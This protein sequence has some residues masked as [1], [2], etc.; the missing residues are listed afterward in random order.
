[1]DEVTKFHR[2]SGLGGSLG[3][4][5]PIGERGIGY[6]CNSLAFARWT[7]INGGP[8]SLHVQ[9][10]GNQIAN[11]YSSYAGTFEHKVGES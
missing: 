10:K 9:D 8:N 1:M 3:A 5:V 2:H 6:E 7:A 4:E 11:F